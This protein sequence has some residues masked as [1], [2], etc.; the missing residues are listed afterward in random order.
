M[1]VSRH[2]KSHGEQV[3]VHDWAH[4]HG[5]LDHSLWFASTVTVDF[6]LQAY[7]G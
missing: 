4:N 5:L 7:L 6:P 3:E 1:L 2:K